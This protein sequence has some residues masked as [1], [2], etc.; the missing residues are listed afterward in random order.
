M[1]CQCF[2]FCVQSSSGGFKRIFFRCVC[3]SNTR[4]SMASRAIW[5]SRWTRSITTTRGLRACSGYVIPK[6]DHR[7]VRKTKTVPKVQFNVFSNEKTFTFWS[8]VWRPPFNMQSRPTRIAERI[9]SQWELR[10]ICYI[11]ESRNFLSW[12][13]RVIFCLLSL[14]PRFWL[15]LQRIWSRFF[16]WSDSSRS[17]LISFFFFLRKN[18]FWNARSQ[19]YI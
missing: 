4:A 5:W 18:I 14:A 2:F 7:Q 1:I 16:S 3:C 15:E 19:K 8:D 10:H 9:E 11:S 12:H 13:K 6:R 17:T